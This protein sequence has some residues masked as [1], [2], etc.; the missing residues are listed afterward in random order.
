VDISLNQKEQIL[1]EV[2]A[3][4]AGATLSYL[5]AL[6]KCDVQNL[7]GRLLGSG[8]YLSIGGQTYIL[9]AEH[10]FR[11][12]EKTPGLIVHSIGYGARPEPVGKIVVREAP[13][14]IAVCEVGPISKQG[15]SDFAP[16]DGNALARRRYEALPIEMLAENSDDLD[17][18]VLF[19]HGFVGER[20]KFFEMAKGIISQTFSY[21]TFLGRSSYAWFDPR[22]HLAVE[23][24]TE[25]QED[26][27]GKKVSKM[28]D[29]NGLSGS[30]LWRANRKYYGLTDWHP[31]L[32][33]VVGIVTHW[34]QPAQSLIATRIEAVHAALSKIRQ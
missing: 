24:P 31:G 3:S 14:D 1:K 27:F 9:T 13:A 16:N 29:P 8:A 5:A 33:R 22:I 6:Y 4:M 20:S 23:Y 21:A 28:P 30:V 10:N 11:E 17:G 19:V 25:G 32:A 7:T 15:E 26:E 18:D 12:G 34:D 2:R